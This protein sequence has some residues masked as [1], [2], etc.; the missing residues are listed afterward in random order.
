MINKPVKSEEDT[1][2]D[3]VLPILGIATIITVGEIVL[4]NIITSTVDDVVRDI[5]TQALS[6]TDFISEQDWICEPDACEFCQ[7][8]ADGGPYPVG[9]HIDTHYNCRCWWEP[10]IEKAGIG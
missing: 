4:K 5:T 9:T 2:L 6:E 7:Q 3:A 8:I 10:H 1:I